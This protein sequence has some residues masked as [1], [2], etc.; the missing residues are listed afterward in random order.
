MRSSTRTF[1]GV[2]G[3]TTALAAPAV[4]LPGA[5]LAKAPLIGSGSSVAQP[6]LLALF[7]GYKKVHS[8]INFVYTADGGNAGVKD[9]QQH[10][11]QFAVQTRPQLPTDLHTR[12]IKLF[13]DGLCIG[14]N[15][16]N[17][18][19]GL[20]ISQ[21]RDIFT[22]VVTSWSLVA[23]S[24]LRTTIAPIGR[25]SA[26]GT[27]TFFQQAVLRGQTQASNVNPL[28]S[29]GLVA[30]A[31]KND[32]NAIGY[33]GLAHSKPGSGVKRLK[34]NGVACDAAHIKNEKYPLFRYIWAV[35]P[36]K[37]PNTDVEKFFDW[38]RTSKAAGK[39]IAAAGAVP[40]FNK[41]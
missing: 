41:S 40:A 33:V 29:D 19:R 9:V 35:L 34:L 38:V 12:Y 10:V 4:A 11:S 8:N 2:L 3:A 21:T 6:Y 36:S 1:I 25:N 24:N 23:G 17:S 16:A 22:D 20:S 15:P 39:I 7:K 13:L 30:T 37:K 32:P 14:V 27:Y 26:A 28:T 18:L 5:A 31:I